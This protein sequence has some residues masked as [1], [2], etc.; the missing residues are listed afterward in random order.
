MFRSD[1]A[2]YL[3][4]DIGAPI[5]TAQARV[6][7]SDEP[8]W[9]RLAVAGDVG[10][11]GAEVYRTAEVMDTLDEQSQFHALLLLGDNV[12][13]S[14][15]PDHVQA[16]VFDPFEAVLDH[17]TE[18]VAALGNHDV[19]NG[20][21]PAHAE[22]LG[23]PNQWYATE[24]GNVL[25]ITLDSNQSDDQAQLEWL[26]STLT[27]PRPTWTIVTMHHP[28]YS[29]GKHGSDGDVRR[30]FVPLFEEFGVDLVLS[31]HDHDYQRSTPMNGI[32]YV[33]SG[34]AAKLRPAGRDAFTAVSWSTYSFVDLV[35]Y[36]DRLEGQA[37]DHDGRAIDN[38]VIQARSG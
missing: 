38:F 28:A 21:G 37:I 1:I 29:A 6:I 13:P 20:N 32:T 26:R 11:G 12:Y 8:A 17:N 19:R 5:E 31:G 2:A 23:M 16:R 30:H 27:G 9:V 34:A 35:V 18:L 22:A 24:I 36:G 25:V 3:T 7:S 10:T 33:V 14:G 15:D 4:N